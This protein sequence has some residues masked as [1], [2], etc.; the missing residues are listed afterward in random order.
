MLKLSVVEKRKG[1]FWA[2]D[3]R[4]RSSG[5]RRLYMAANK[6]GVAVVVVVEAGTLS[7]M[8]LLA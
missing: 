2:G 6:I 5:L 4:G 8:V 1:G 7:G 3:E